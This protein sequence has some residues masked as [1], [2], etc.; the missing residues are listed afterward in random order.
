MH[1]GFEGGVEFGAAIWRGLCEEGWSVAGRKE[2]LDLEKEAE[3][4]LARYG[5]R[6]DHEKREARGEVRRSRGGDEV[7]LHI[8][9]LADRKARRYRR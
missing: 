2:S 9:A 5:G 7:N 3:G 1:G 4:Q 6:R 8:H